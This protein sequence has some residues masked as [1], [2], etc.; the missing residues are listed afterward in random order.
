MSH[1]IITNS[2]QN[3]R[4]QASYKLAKSIFVINFGMPIKLYKREDFEYPDLIREL[5]PLF[6][7]N[8]ELFGDYKVYTLK[9]TSDNLF[10]L[11]KLFSVRTFHL[12]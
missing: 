6:E 9:T 2:E 3:A 8:A 5:R 4:F 11:F 7:E 12:S 10:D 1:V